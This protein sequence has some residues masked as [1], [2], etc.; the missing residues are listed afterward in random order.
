MS[1][2]NCQVEGRQGRHKG[3]GGV[4]VDQDQ[5]R[6]PGAGPLLSQSRPGW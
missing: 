3:G 1:H 5:V 2:G 6:L 4:A